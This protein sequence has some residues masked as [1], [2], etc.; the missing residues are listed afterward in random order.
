M[1][2]YLIIE[3]M[4]L[5]AMANFKQSWPPG[6]NTWSNMPRY[7]IKLKLTNEQ[8][9]VLSKLKGGRDISFT[10]KTK[11]GKFFTGYLDIESILG[12][13]NL[14]S[15]QIIQIEVNALEYQEAPKDLCRDMVLNEVLG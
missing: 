8:F 15:H 13:S 6:K 12:L 5:E 9:S 4:K 2:S 1:N 7:K 10:H 14:K 3:D 11:E